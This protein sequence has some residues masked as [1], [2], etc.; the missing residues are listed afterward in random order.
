[1]PA[2]TSLGPFN[3]LK[4]DGTPRGLKARTEIVQRPGI[5]G[6][7]VW[8]NGTRGEP[9]QLVSYVDESTHLLAQQLMQTYRTYIKQTLRLDWEQQF[10]GNCTVL[11]VS[12]VRIQRLASSSGG[13]SSGAGALL[14]ARWTLITVST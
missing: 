4:V 3:F 9:F 12:P 5:D 8:D 14:V 10:F 2:T 7:E 1:M 13:L 11:D 6:V